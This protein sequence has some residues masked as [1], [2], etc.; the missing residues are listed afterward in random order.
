MGYPTNKRSSFISA[1]QLL[2][3]K[4]PLCLYAVSWVKHGDSS[5]FYATCCGFIFRAGVCDN[6]NHLFHVTYQEADTTNVIFLTREP[7]VPH[8][9]SP[10]SA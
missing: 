2:H 6:R 5:V 8:T 9:P 1:F 4:C 3:T 10:N 7:A